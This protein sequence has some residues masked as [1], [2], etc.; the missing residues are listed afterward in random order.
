MPILTTQKNPCTLCKKNIPKDA[1]CDALVYPQLLCGDCIPYV[2][3][4][5]DGT[6]TPRYTVNYKNKLFSLIRMVEL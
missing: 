4:K 3:L 6:Y 5:P 2:K 1:M